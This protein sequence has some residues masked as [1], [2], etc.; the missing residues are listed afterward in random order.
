LLFQ[1]IKST[2]YKGFDNM[3]LENDNYIYIYKVTT[4]AT[5]LKYV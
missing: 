3:S 5:K 1:Y 2:F 4:Q